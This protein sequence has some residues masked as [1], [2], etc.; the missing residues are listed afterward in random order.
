MIALIDGDIVAFRCAASCQTTGVLATDPTSKETVV[1]PVEIGYARVNEM[2]DS[3]LQEV[4]TREY[5]VFLTDSDGNFRKTVSPDYKANRKDVARPVLLPQLN[6]F[7]IQSW[8]AVRAVGEEADD[9]L[10]IQQTALYEQAK[11]PFGLAA[12]KEQGDHCPSVIC[13]IDKDLHQIPGK[14]YN[15]VKKE[16]SFISE[17]EGKY[18]FYKQLLMGDSTDNIKGCSGIGPKK[19]EKLLDP[20]MGDEEAMMQV[21][22]ETYEKCFSEMCSDERDELITTVGRLVYIRKHTGEL[23]TI[24]QF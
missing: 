2:M 1:L 13:S 7:L 18:F 8:G 24:P 6:E 21:V 5:K 19:A 9:L 14:H 12:V 22:W 15:F 23:W 16:V 11:P 17:D 10:G 3:I 4:G 20:A